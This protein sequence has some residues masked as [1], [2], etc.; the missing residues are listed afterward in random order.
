MK[1]VTLILAILVVALI[2]DVAFGESL[3][4]KCGKRGKV[5]WG[6]TLKSRGRPPVTI[7]KAVTVL[8][9]N[10]VRRTLN[11]GQG[12]HSCGCDKGGTCV[13]YG[14]KAALGHTNA[15]GT[16][17]FA[18]VPA[19]KLGIKS[20]KNYHGRARGAVP[21]AKKPKKVVKRRIISTNIRT[22]DIVHGPGAPMWEYTW[23]ANGAMVT[24]AETPASLYKGTKK[25]GTG[26]NTGLFRPGK[27]V[28]YDVCAP[29]IKTTVRRW[30]E[31]VKP[32]QGSGSVTWVLGYIKV[33]GNAKVWAFM[34]ESIQIGGRKFNGNIA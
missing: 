20:G 23:L 25:I 16:T 32:W 22:Q 4:K 27:H 17:F 6:K 33:K 28:F 14:D 18:N 3:G 9:N 11:K 8:A 29:K 30:Q 21:L 5:S 2:A 31:A 19:K 10:G 24:G 12:F 1:A 7:K 34:I 13:I 15:D 26:Y